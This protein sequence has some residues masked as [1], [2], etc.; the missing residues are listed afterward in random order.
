MAGAVGAIKVSFFKVDA[1]DKVVLVARCC[2][3]CAAHPAT[4]RVLGCSYVDR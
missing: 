3:L 4:V 2:C 1:E